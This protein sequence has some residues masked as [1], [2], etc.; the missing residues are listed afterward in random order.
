MGPTARRAPCPAHESVVLS[1]I[2]PCWNALSYT[3]RCLAS[4]VRWT[5]VVH[6]LILI[7]NG[8]EDGTAEFLRSFRRRHLRRN[9]ARGAISTLHGIHLFFNG[10]N[11]GF[12]RAINQGMRAAR[13]K[14]VVWLNNDVV[15]TPG[16]A[17]GLV[18][19]AETS[20]T[21]GAVGPRAHRT[22]GVQNVPGVGY[23]IIGQ[24]P[25]FAEAWAMKNGGGLRFTD[26]LL[27][28][29]LLVTSEAV[30]RIGFV[31]ER[32]GLG[33]YE[34][35][36]Y[37]YRLARAGYRLA[38][39]EGVFVHHE[40]H[41]TFRANGVDVSRTEND[42]LAKLAAKWEFPKWGFPLGTRPKCEE[43]IRS[44]E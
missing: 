40:L 12:P 11:R 19:C 26:R 43:V 20:T 32:F 28:F 27:G 30:R 10:R 13:G 39:A 33:G 34:D 1:I 22:G 15:V 7:D 18:A 17:E 5:S 8:S 21:I 41:A 35:I 23:K 16:W 42:C 44:Q 29:C 4:V 3:E 14:Y 31:D 36:D 38:V 37:C 2:V 24:L 25:Y 9:G 6:E